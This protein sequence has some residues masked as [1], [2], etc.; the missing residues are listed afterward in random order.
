MPRFGPSHRV[1]ASCVAAA[2]LYFGA[3][4]ALGQSDAAAGGQPSVS[5]SLAG[6]RAGLSSDA[7]AG[8]QPDIS[9][10]LAGGRAGFPA[11]AFP[12]SGVR[13]GRGTGGTSISSKFVLP[14][15]GVGVVDAGGGAFL[16]RDHAF[17]GFR[18][19]G[20]IRSFGPRIGPVGTSFGFPSFRRGGF[21]YP[22]SVAYEVAPT[23]TVLWPPAPPQPPRV[24]READA[25]P[26]EPP[27][28]VEMGTAALASGN[29]AIAVEHYREALRQRES[30]A[31]ASSGADQAMQATRTELM[32]ALGIALLAAGRTQQGAAVLRSAYTESPDLAREPFPAE[33]V[34]DPRDRRRT[35][36]RT[37]EEA[38]RVGSASLWLAVTVLMQADGRTEPARRM[39][40]RAAEQGLEAGVVEVF[41]T[42]LGASG[43]ASTAAG[44]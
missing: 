6:G 23:R 43:V 20:V 34:G 24:A 42:Q 12:E 18:G 21:G 29:A 33:T 32:R 28:P 36:R 39:L 15:G 2:S 22:V 31:G 19:V 40:H 14:S 25:Q 4:S 17:T 7:I 5:D 41:A 27:T 9:G 13:S 8:G 10:S 16:L 44:G 1:I 35:L 3:G 38:H 37:V 30:G 11:G 26:P